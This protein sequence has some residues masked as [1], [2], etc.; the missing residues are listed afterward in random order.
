[1]TYY[2]LLVAL[3]VEV[4]PGLEEQYLWAMET[5]MTIQECEQLKEEATPYFEMLGGELSCEVDDAV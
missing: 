5:D 2:V 4:G 3:W 1:M